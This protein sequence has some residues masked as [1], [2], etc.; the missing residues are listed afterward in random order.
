MCKHVCVCIHNN[1]ELERLAVERC[2]TQMLGTE[3]RTSVGAVGAPNPYIRAFSSLGTA[4]ENLLPF[5]LAGGRGGGNNLQ[6]VGKQRKK[7]CVIM[8]LLGPMC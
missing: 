2:L 7:A 1:E 5:A 6:L 4:E 8:S 3:L